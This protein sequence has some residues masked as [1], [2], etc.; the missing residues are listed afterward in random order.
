MVALLD[1]DFL[2]YRV[3]FAKGKDFLQMLDMVDWY[4]SDIIRCTEADEYKIFLSGSTNFRKEVATIQEYKGTRKK[5]KPEYYWDVRDYMIGTWKAEVSEGCEAD[6]LCGLYQTEDT[7]VVG[8]DKD[9]L[10]IPGHHYR[11][12]RKWEENYKLFVTEEE[13]K[14]NFFL[15]C[16][17]GDTSDNVLGLLNPEKLHFKKPVKF[18]EETALQVLDGK[19]PEEMKSTVT[20][21]Y[22]KIHN[23]EWYKRLDE[24]CRLLYLQRRDKKEYYDWI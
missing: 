17:V 20:D 7:I 19:S 6:D 5:E 10:T 15:Q 21:L 4:I 22:K 23:N 2:V 11:I 8:E 14:R 3:C 9:L 12:K 24:T 1:A 13:A 18:S 16:L